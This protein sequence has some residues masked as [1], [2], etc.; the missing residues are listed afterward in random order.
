V[1]WGERHRGIERRHP[2]REIRIGD[3]VQQIDVDGADTG[4][5]GRGHALGDVS[6]SVATAELAQLGV[7][8]R[9]RPEGDPGD[10]GA[11]EGRRF[12]TLVGT[13]VG[14]ERDLGALRDPEPLADPVQEPRDLVGGE[15]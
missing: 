13:G 15:Q 12:A 1:V 3:V 10:P 2:R 7:V 8:E 4:L 9:L 5:S 6:G 11:A 14:L